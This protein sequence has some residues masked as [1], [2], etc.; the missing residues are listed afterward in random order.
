MP[1]VILRRPP[2]ESRPREE[3]SKEPAI[4]ATAFYT[5]GTWWF[6]RSNA[7][8]CYAHLLRTFLNPDFPGTTTRPSLRARQ[9][10]LQP[11]RVQDVNR[12]L[13]YK[14]VAASNACL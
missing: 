3:L 8:F 11:E 6:S 7:G 9:I 10:F 4:A 12:K 14:I 1:M 13:T 2:F 5:S